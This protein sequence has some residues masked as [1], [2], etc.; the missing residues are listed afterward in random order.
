MRLATDEGDVVAGRRRPV[1]GR[2]YRE[3]RLVCSSVQ[4]TIGRGDRLGL[5]RHE[6]RYVVARFCGRLDPEL[7]GELTALVRRRGAAA[8]RLA[9]SLAPIEIVVDDAR[10]GRQRL[11]ARLQ[12]PQWRAG[13][14]RAVEFGLRELA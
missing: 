3:G 6:R 9:E 2:A 1:A 4:L 14:L 12:P 10:R 13:D 11:V 7:R 5:A 8:A